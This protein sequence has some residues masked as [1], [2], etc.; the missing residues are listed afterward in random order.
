MSNKGEGAREPSK[1]DD[2]RTVHSMWM[3]R[4][5]VRTLV[6]GVGYEPE[7]PSFDAI[8]AGFGESTELE[9]I[10]VAAVYAEIRNLKLVR[11]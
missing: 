10:I 5:I 2:P 1:V 11:G 7:T 6:D 4:S 9:R 3:I 8:A